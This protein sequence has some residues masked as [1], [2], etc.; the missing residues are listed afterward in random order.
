MNNN[1]GLIQFFSVPGQSCP[2]DSLSFCKHYIICVPFF[3]SLRERVS[4]RDT[5]P[6]VVLGAGKG[7]GFFFQSQHK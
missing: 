7:G 6:S 3:V 2:G 4:L 1:N 5:P